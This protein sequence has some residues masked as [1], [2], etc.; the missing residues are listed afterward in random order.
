MGSVCV[1][2]GGRSPHL[3]TEILQP[4]KFPWQRDSGRL[5]NL[6]LQGVSSLSLSKPCK[7]TTREEITKL[8]CLGFQLPTPQIFTQRL[9]SLA[10]SFL[11]TLIYQ[12]V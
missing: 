12:R 11:P 3:A 9:P 4:G 6:A 10:P 7:V 5:A 2:G 8:L 1:C